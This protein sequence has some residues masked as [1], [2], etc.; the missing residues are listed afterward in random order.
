VQNENPG[1]IDGGRVRDADERDAVGPRGTYP[2]HDDRIEQQQRQ[3]RRA[4]ETVARVATARA[5]GPERCGR[6][7]GYS[8]ARRNIR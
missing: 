8:F 5:A 1:E 6:R 7:R 4:E 3:Q 2:P